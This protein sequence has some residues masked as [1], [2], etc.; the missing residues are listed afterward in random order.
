[1][2]LDFLAF[3]AG[4]LDTIQLGSF[5][6][7]YVVNCEIHTRST[8]HNIALPG[9]INVTQLVKFEAIAGQETGTEQR[10]RRH[11]FSQSFGM[12]V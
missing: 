7:C 5:R 9:T 3:V 11:A 6:S 1:M 4:A 8:D 2:H 10:R 12:Q